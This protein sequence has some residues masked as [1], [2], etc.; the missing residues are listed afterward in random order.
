[1]ALP[2]VGRSWDPIIGRALSGCATKSN[3]KAV[4]VSLNIPLATGTLRNRQDT[5]YWGHVS[6]L[7]LKFWYCSDG[8]LCCHVAKILYSL[9]IPWRY[10]ASFAVLGPLLQDETGPDDARFNAQEQ[11]G[12]ICQTA[13]IFERRKV[14]YHLLVKKKTQTLIWRARTEREN[15]SN[16]MDLWK[17]EGSISLANKKKHKH[18][19]Y[20]RTHWDNSTCWFV[21]T[22]GERT[23]M[24]RRKIVL[25]QGTQVFLSAKNRIQFSLWLDQRGG[26]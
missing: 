17:A 21:L 26:K 13:W 3:L 23:L 24:R 18:W 7:I 1:M 11:R 25:V 14:W 8:S 4:Y 22:F 5:R 9:K 2:C 19:F 16:C 20:A 10:W 12:R 6:R 15:L